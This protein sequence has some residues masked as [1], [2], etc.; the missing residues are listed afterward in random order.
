MT[1]LSP[2]QAEALTRRALFPWYALTIELDE[3]YHFTTGPDIVVDGVPYLSGYVRGL[4]TTATGCTL[5]I[6]NDDRR[7]TMLAMWGEYI[8]KPFSLGHA[9]APDRLYVDEDGVP[10]AD[11]ASVPYIGEKGAGSLHL[12]SGFVA[13]TPEAGEWLTIN[14]DRSAG[15][16]PRDRILPPFA[17]HTR[18]EGTLLAV[19]QSTT[20]IMTRSRN[21]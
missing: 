13:D 3:V 12:M 17:R 5:A 19:N 18:P 10:Y 6:R 16:V 11:Q 7:H 4:R 9:L 1:I 2:D 15:T 8:R 21:A 20:K 14:I